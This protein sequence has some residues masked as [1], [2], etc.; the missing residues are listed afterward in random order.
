MSAANRT[1]RALAAVAGLLGTMALVAG[2]TPAPGGAGEVTALELAAEL[3]AAPDSVIILDIRDEPSYREF[4]APRARLAETG[5]VL[6][7]V[8]AA[9]ATDASLIVVAGGI[10]HDP[11][12]AWLALRRA[13]YGRAHY[14]PDVLGSWLDDIISPTLPS[15]ASEAER[16]AWETQADLSR[17]FGG[18]PRI[19]EASSGGS[20]DA[21]SRLRR[22]KR[23]GCAF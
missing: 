11:R 9:G 18:F 2:D 20:E 8:E 10:E 7:A 13:G 1:N 4:H 6:E 19:V 22:A 23:R 5:R 15:S 17:Y 14:L 3:R 21:G 16:E 12:P